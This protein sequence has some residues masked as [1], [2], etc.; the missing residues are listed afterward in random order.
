MT[1]KTRA[2]ISEFIEFEIVYA[3]IKHII[4]MTGRRIPFGISII[5]SNHFS[6][7]RP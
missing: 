3:P 6:A 7:N 5:L 1:P 4:R 2:T